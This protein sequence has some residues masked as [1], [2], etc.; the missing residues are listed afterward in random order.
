MLRSGAKRSP[1]PCRDCGGDSSGPGRRCRSCA[2]AYRKNKTRPPRP[3]R[4]C[5]RTIQ[6]APSRMGHG[7]Y[8]S[9]LCRNA[10]RLRLIETTCTRCGG[11]FQ[12]TQAALKSTK[13]PFCSQVCSRAFN[14]GD[15]HQ[16][17]RG[18]H[19]PNRGP[20][21]QKRA[22]TIR[23]RDEYRCIRCGKSQEENGEKL[24]VDHRI[25]WRYLPKKLANH[26]DNLVSLCRPC[27]S[28]KTATERRWIDGNVQ[29]FQRYLQLVR[30]PCVHKI[31]R[32]YKSLD[33]ASLEG[34]A[35][36]RLVK[37]VR[38]VDKP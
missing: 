19:D 9:R 16:G 30:A 38:K 3:C 1:K 22:E 32:N 13:R 23:E 6:P 29:E 10:E 26:P 2:Y 33:I 25:P 36:G 34:I 21:W 35:L 37:I 24:S 28:W 12:R 31:S 5:G 14:R 18:G 17:W 27:H 7:K 20:K 4:T 8:C 15:R 11:K